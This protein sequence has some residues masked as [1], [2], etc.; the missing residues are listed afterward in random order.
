MPALPKWSFLVFGL[1][2]GA[3]YAAM[4]AFSEGASAKLSTAAVVVIDLAG[5]DWS[6]A[7]P[8]RLVEFVTPKRLADISAQS[9]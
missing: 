1:C 7:R 9:D 6:R 2:S 3:N 4:A 8:G 5:P